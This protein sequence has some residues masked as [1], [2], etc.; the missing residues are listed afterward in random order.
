[1]PF[2]LANLKK[3]M[4]YVGLAH[5]SVESMVE[6]M[7]LKGCKS[8]TSNDIKDHLFLYRNNARFT[9]RTFREQFDISLLNHGE[10]C[11]VKKN[12]NPL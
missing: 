4:T 8:L 12:L 10:K 6:S 5:S 2:D 11:I 9:R 7:H 1:M 3:Q